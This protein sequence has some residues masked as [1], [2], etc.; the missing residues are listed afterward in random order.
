MK[1]W[2]AENEGILKLPREPR[3][4]MEGWGTENCEIMIVAIVKK[5]DGLWQ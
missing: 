1:R 5:E 4:S 3:R 2:G